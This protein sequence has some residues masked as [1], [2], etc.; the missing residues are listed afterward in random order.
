MVSEW[1]SYIVRQTGIYG[2]I[3]NN[4]LSTPANIILTALGIW[5]ISS[6]VPSFL[7]WAL[8][9]A[10]WVGTSPDD[11]GTDGACW[12]FIKQQFNIII[13]GFYP[14]DQLWRP[15]F[16][17]FATIALVLGYKL[18]IGR[19]GK[20]FLSFFL[21][22]I[23]PF[24]ITAIL[25]GTLFGIEFFSEVET[26]RW[27]GLMLT[28][29]LSAVGILASFPIGILLALGRRSDNMP[30]IRAFCIIFIEFWR[31]V[32]L[33][34][35]L[36]MASVMLP[37]FLPEGSDFEKLTRALIGITLFEAAYMAEVI[38]GGLQSIPR[39][40]YEACDALGLGYWRKMILVI[41]PQAIKLVIPGIVN[42]CIALFKDTSL[43]S[44]IGL[45][46]LLNAAYN[47]TRDP[48]WL[49]YT[50]EGFAFTALI[51][52]IFCFGMSQYSQI[53]ERRLSYTAKT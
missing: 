28:L 33:I 37:L 24:I 43:V 36:F 41:L 49:A 6:T 23:Y 13:Y 11:C 16:V 51:Y 21:L 40:Q 4:L 20:T 46:D 35:V 14:Q 15:N 53:L 5:F 47:A 7:N 8:F 48:L 44:I 50:I 3:L 31:G 27:G 38:R 1:R 42:T 52:F 12:V 30:I 10:Y 39:G 26:D 19:K 25:H 17:F 45:W 2:W 32:P 34:T 29:V 18:P 9:N 22:L